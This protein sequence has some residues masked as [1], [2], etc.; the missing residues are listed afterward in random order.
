M[1]LIYLLLIGLLFNACKNEEHNP[2][3]VGRW[4]GTTWLIE[5]QPSDI[6]AT[7]VRFEFSAE[8]QYTAQMSQQRQSGTW[9]NV[10]DKLYTT[11]TGQKQILVKILSLDAQA[12]SMEM[13]RGGRKEVLSL[14][15]VE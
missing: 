5:D 8:G 7:K 6:D 3:L 10:G 15:R 11:E 14:K 4:Q 1:R 9:Y 12:F 2:L 13:N